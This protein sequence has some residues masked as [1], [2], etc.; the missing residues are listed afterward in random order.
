MWSPKF[1]PSKSEMLV[2]WDPSELAAGIWFRAVL[3]GLCS[4]TC[5]ICINYR[6]LTLELNGVFNWTLDA[7]RTRPS[8]CGWHQF[9]G[10]LLH[11]CPKDS[12]LGHQVPFLS[13]MSLAPVLHSQPPSQG[14]VVFCSTIAFFPTSQVQE[15]N[16]FRRL[17]PTLGIL[18]GWVRTKFSQNLG[19]WCVCVWDVGSCLSV[20]I[21][22]L[23]HSFIFSLA[24]HIV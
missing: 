16:I 14:A 5:G 12:L 10:D 6:K 20:I 17:K 7:G 8:R 2:A 11:S 19:Q 21:F 23:S 4:W 1:V 22:L 9:L 3:W 18:P 24:Q 13:Q 15:A